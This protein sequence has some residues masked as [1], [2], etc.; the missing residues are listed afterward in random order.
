MLKLSAAGVE[1]YNDRADMTTKRERYSVPAMQKN[2]NCVIEVQ[3]KQ[4]AVLTRKGGLL[5]EEMARLIGSESGG[6]T[7]SGGVR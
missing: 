3:V 4:D 7:G 5:R 6:E 1:M 2:G